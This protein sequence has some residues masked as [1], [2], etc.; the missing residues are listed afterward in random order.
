MSDTSDPVR[1]VEAAGRALNAGDWA[2]VAAL[3]DP[4]SLRAHRRGLLDQYAPAE[5]PRV[6]TVDEYR[7]AVPDMPREVAEYHL[8]R[9]ADQFDAAR[10]LADELPGIGSVE[11]L[12]TLPEATVFTA[13]LEGHSIGGRIRR[14]IA[15]G[16]MPAK[17]AALVLRH[18]HD[19]VVVG[20]LPD[21]AGLAH[22]VYR[23]RIEAHDD[24]AELPAWLADRPADERALARELVGMPPR[25]QTCRRQPDGSWR[26]VVGFE[27][28]ETG[29]MGMLI[30]GPTD[31]AAAPGPDDGQ[32]AA[33]PAR[34]A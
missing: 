26:L 21:G 27:F 13:W 15:D 1:L 24:G 34:D 12:R 23:E 25:V 20:A 4:V 6:P 19:Y 3:C 9:M 31:D 10:S 16:S 28:F 5:P 7:R 14:A 2:A 11:A 17:D 22:V 33:H 8:A 18:V 32:A 30:A 29:A